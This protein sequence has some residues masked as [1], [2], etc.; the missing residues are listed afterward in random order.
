VSNIRNII[1]YL[2]TYLLFLPKILESMKRIG[3]FYASTSG[4]TEEVAKKIKHKLELS[5]EHMY[6]IAEAKAED[7]E[8]YDILLMGIPT[9]G[10][11]E[12]HE[13]WEGF[14]P[15]VEKANLSNRKVALFGLGDQEGNSD[16]FCD[17]MGIIYKKLAEL[18]VSLIGTWSTE[19]YEFDHSEAQI[20]GEFAGLAIDEDNQ[21][22]LTD[23]RID[24]WLQQLSEHM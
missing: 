23:K 3:I 13:D 4:N 19:G 16:S 12:L 15:E 24:Q 17:A 10:V 22:E 7:M 20:N 8:N 9:W 2:N 14:L 11:G 6:N 5:D 21:S 1:W 18:S